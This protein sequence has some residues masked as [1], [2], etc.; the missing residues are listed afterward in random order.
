[1]AALDWIC[2]ALLAASTL[3]G[4][5]RGLIYEA[6]SVAAWVVAFL[7]A[8]IA[9]PW[10]G[11][12]LPMGQ[13]AESL[14]V[15]AA[16]VILFIVFAFA[17]GLVASLARG[18]VRSVGVRAVDRT[19]GMVFGLIR[20]VLLLL[21]LAFVIQLLGQGGAPWWRDSFSGPWLQA[22]LV[23]LAPFLP[24]HLSAAVTG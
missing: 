7:L 10:L 5:W 20:G 21:L 8:R 4:A 17:G 11:G 9:A 15:A 1:M 12:V 3:L 13:S 24:P 22:A 23:Q 18:V 6:L 19:F 14:R 2:L 16:F